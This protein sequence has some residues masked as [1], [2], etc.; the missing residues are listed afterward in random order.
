MTLI[1]AEGGGIVDPSVIPSN[2]EWP[3]N[4]MSNNFVP[5]VVNNEAVFILFHVNTDITVRRMSAFVNSASGNIDVGIYE[6]D[7]TRLVSSGSTVLA[8]GGQIFD[9]A[10]TPLT[11]GRF[12]MSLVLSSVGG[13]RLWQWMNGDE[14]GSQSH[15]SQGVIGMK[16]QIAAFPLPANAVFE[17]PVVNDTGG[18]FVMS[19]LLEA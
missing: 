18:L 16:K 2:Q 19:L 17:E 9:I 15:P 14:G 10:D 3:S 7:G 8:N 1:R 6:L 11:A 13:T 4:Q 5:D 12:Y